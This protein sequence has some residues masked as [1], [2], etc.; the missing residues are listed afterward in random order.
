METTPEK[1]FLDDFIDRKLS[2]KDFPAPEESLI[3][4]RNKRWPTTWE[5]NVQGVP[6]MALASEERRANY[7]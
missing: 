4:T 1:S 6:S 3:E 7:M 2:P 5:N